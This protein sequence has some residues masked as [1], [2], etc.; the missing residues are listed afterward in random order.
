MIFYLK[1]Q[2]IAELL[3]DSDYWYKAKT[4]S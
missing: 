3:I 2:T 1:K 4:I